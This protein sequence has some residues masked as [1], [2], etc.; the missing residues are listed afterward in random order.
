MGKEKD[1]EREERE[2]LDAESNEEMEGKFNPCNR[3]RKRLEPVLPGRL[4]LRS[5]GDAITERRGKV[6]MGEGKEVKE[7]GKE[8]IQRQKEF[9]TVSCFKCITV[10]HPLIL[11][12]YQNNA[13]AASRTSSNSSSTGITMEAVPTNTNTHTHTH[14]WSSNLNHVQLKQLIWLMSW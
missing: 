2:H 4:D 13:P 14:T 10:T 8:E 1:T 7:G 12:L 3:Y 5:R 9:L 11:L 6:Q